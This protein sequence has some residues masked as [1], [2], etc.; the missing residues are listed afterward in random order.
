MLSRL[1][2]LS[3]SELYTP[4]SYPCANIWLCDFWTVHCNSSHHTN[5]SCYRTCLK[6][7]TEEHTDPPCIPAGKWSQSSHLPFCACLIA[8]CS[9]QGAG[10]GSVVH[11]SH[12]SLNALKSFM[13]DIFT[14]SGKILG[15]EKWGSLLCRTPSLSPFSWR[16]YPLF[17]SFF[18]WCALKKHSYF[19]VFSHNLLKNKYKR[20]WMAPLII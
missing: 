11:C 10:H 14:A 19:V 16:F 3:L 5:M 4:H 8:A 20:N 9:C 17:S 2:R 6:C 13:G 7:V 12:L 18:L 1:S 15:A